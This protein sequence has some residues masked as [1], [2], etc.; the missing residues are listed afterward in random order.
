MFQNFHLKSLSLVWVNL[1]LS[2]FFK[3]MLS[4]YRLDSQSGHSSP[5]HSASQVLG[6]QACGTIPA[7]IYQMWYVCVR[8]TLKFPF[9]RAREM[10]QCVRAYITLAEARFWF[11]APIWCSQPSVTPL[12]Q[13]PSLFSVL[14]RHC[15]YVV[16]IPTCK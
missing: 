11:P 7:N 10:A 15:T 16:H 3:D 5:S 4:L 12:S 6:L 2:V 9:L 14:V 13:N 1:F 8:I